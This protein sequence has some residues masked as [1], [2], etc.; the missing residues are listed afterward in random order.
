MRRWSPGVA[1]ILFAVL[2]GLLRFSTLDAQSFAFDEARTAVMVELPFSEMLDEVVRSENNPPLYFIVIWTWAQALGPGEVALRSLSALA[3]TLTIPAAFLAARFFASRRVAGA[4]AG[5]VATNPLLVWYSQEARSYAL[6]VLLTSVGFLF[7]ARVLRRPNSRDLLW[8]SAFAVL[9]LATHYSALFLLAGMATVLLS[10][11]EIRRAA[12]A[13]LSAVAL[14]GIALVPLAVAQGCDLALHP[15]VSGALGLLLRL[16]KKVLLGPT[17]N[18]GTAELA[19]TLVAGA[20]AA[21]ALAVL[22]LRG[23]ARERRAAV[24]AGIAGSGL[25]A[26]LV[27]LRA[28][29][30]E[31][32]D[33]RFALPAVLP[34]LVILALGLGGRRAGPAGVAA[35]AALVV[36]GVA[37]SAL[38]LSDPDFQ[39][40]DWRGVAESLGHSEQARVLV[41]TPGD[42]P[43]PLLPYLEGVRDLPKRGA[44]TGEIVLAALP[45][46][47]DALAPLPLSPG[48]A[49]PRVPFRGFRLVQRAQTDSYVVL[50]YTAPS[51][52][53]ISAADLHRARLDRTQGASLL[54]QDL[55]FADLRFPDLS[56]GS[57]PLPADLAM[58]TVAPRKGCPPS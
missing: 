5:L 2:G 21:A 17:I 33:V 16:P 53:R 58:E 50:R 9:A 40:E 41:V 32:V 35:G 47:G 22:A 14:A 27:A 36:S 23:Q 55:H 26:A 42:G 38:V 29:G 15:D 39:R 52:L 4:T 10:R 54:L 44:T 48:A 19:L 34:S 45:R 56:C 18:A 8:W 1:L 49:P 37:A 51:A 6:L 11:A 46:H 3:G 13:P 12:I 28:V 57:P 24:V 43:L 25:V 30:F 31:D 20:A 7:L